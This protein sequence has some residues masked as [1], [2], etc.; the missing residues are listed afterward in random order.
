MKA[1]VSYT[2]LVTIE[3]VDSYEDA[4]EKAQN[5]ASENGFSLEVNDME[6]DLLDD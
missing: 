2:I 5:Y 4:L 6:V 3:D 1:Y